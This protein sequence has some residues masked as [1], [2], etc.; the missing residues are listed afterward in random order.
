MAKY[1]WTGAGETT[2][3]AP[4]L[5]SNVWG[6]SLSEWEVQTHAEAET[7]GKVLAFANT[8]G[9]NTR[10]ALRLDAAGSSISG[11]VESRGRFWKDNI[12]T[13]PHFSRVFLSG[14]AGSE[15]TLYADYNDSPG[16]GWRIVEYTPN[17]NPLETSGSPSAGAGAGWYRFRFLI[18]PDDTAEPYKL[19]VWEDTDPEPTTPTV[20]STTASSITSGGLGYGLFTAQETYLDWLT[21]GTGTDDADDLGSASTGIS[22]TNPASAADGETGYTG[23]VSTNT[24]EG[25]LYHVVTTSDTKPSLAQV[26]A[27]ED[28]NGAAAPASGSQAV[29]STGSRSVSGTGLTAETTYYIHYQQS[30]ST[31]DSDVVSSPS[32]TTDSAG[33]TEPPL[34]V[35]HDVDTGNIDPA[36]VTVTGAD[37]TTPTVEVTAGRSGTDEWVHFLFAVDDASGKTP[38]FRVESNRHVGW[39]FFSS[40]TPLYSYDMVDWFPATSFTVDTGYYQWSFDEAFTEDRVYIAS[41]P[42]YQVSQ[43]AAFKDNLLSYGAVSPVASADA[44]A[45]IGTSP[46]ETDDLGRAIGA[47]DI[48]GVKFDWGGATTD[49]GRKRVMCL[50]NGAHPGETPDTFMLDGL[51][52]WMLED[53]SQAAQDFRSNWVVYLYFN[54]TPNGRKGGHRRANFRDS[55][56]PNRD[57]S[58]GGFTLAET[59]LIRAS[60]E[61]DMDLTGSGPIDVFFGMH[62]AGSTEDKLYWYRADSMDSGVHNLFDSAV[63]SVSGLPTTPLNSGTNTT[64]PYW[65]AA[66]YGATLAIDLEAPMRGNPDAA[67]YRDSGAIYGAAIQSMDADEVF[68]AVA[69]DQDVTLV[70]GQ[71]V[72]QAVTA[73][74]DQVAAINAIVASQQT[75]SQASPVQQIAALSSVDA[76][77]E[78]QAVSVDISTAAVMDITAILLEQITQAQAVTVDQVAQA[79]AVIAQQLTQG[80]PLSAEQVAELASVVVEQITQAQA[81]DVSI[82]QPDDLTVAVIEQLTQAQSINASQSAQVTGVSAESLTEVQAV[83]VAAEYSLV[84]VTGEQLT[85]ARAVEILD[86]AGLNVVTLEQ[87]TQAQAASVNLA[88]LLQT[89]KGEQATDGQTSVVAATL[90]LSAVD[91]EQLTEA[92]IADVLGSALFVDPRSLRV[93][94]T[95]I[96]YTVNRKTDSFR[97]KPKTTVH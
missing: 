2:G 88:L 38:Q 75:Q 53:A 82:V 57:W 8:T 97:L 80:A 12:G 3:T 54:V 83:A 29:S 48:Y 72:T 86:G 41:H 6:G 74:V 19:W 32:F 46:T 42:V 35:E 47:N 21:F 15:N 24:G 92:E 73:N 13:S 71:Q 58:T 22:L 77:Q 60:M 67:E 5:F 68:V 62:G 93:K 81:V 91:V 66:Q 31:E 18:D 37:T 94:R 90:L 87:A 44:N 28:H 10:R 78:S 51:L 49:G 27:G 7:E 43:M 4:T 9:S 61:S 36:S 65:A 55:L 85:Q 34:T 76:Q 16:Q 95:T 70:S 89:I 20:V 96:G 64:A 26:Q 1:Q 40:W 23:S 33:G 52:T 39:D 59:A 84:T 17:F 45:V 79:A 50:T 11:R 30:S 63:Q 25:D 14:S 56:D 69:A